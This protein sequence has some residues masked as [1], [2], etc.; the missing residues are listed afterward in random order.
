MELTWMGK[1]RTFVEMLI[2]YGNSYAQSYNT[3]GDYGIL[4]VFSPSQLQVLEYILENEEKNQNMAEIAARLGITPSA[5]SKNV[6]KM[7][8][9]G[10]LEKYHT[11]ENRKNV[12][13]RVSELGRKVYEEYTQFA[14]RRVYK[15]IFEILDTVP[16]EYVEKFTHILEISARETQMKRLTQKEVTLIKIDE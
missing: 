10:L 15:E 11:S 1:Y 8:Q 13:I 16:E 9:K 14:Y 3:E 7:T 2:K 5:F 12:I 6:K 4:T